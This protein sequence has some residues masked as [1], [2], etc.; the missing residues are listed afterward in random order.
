M[1]AQIATPYASIYETKDGRILLAAQF[2][3]GQVDIYDL[4]HPKYQVTIL[5]VSDFKF[6]PQFHQDEFGRIF[7]AVQTDYLDFYEILSE[8]RTQHMHSLHSW[9]AT[10]WNGH[11]FTFQ[12]QA[13]FTYF[14]SLAQRFA[15]LKL[16]EGRLDAVEFEIPNLARRTSFSW[17]TSADN[18]FL[19]VQ[20]QKSIRIFQL[21]SSVKGAK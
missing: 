13:H 7:L 4:K 19:G 6:W 2:H 16:A 21:I 18:V 12:G 14:D 9:P 3:K 1:T 10:Y 5:N 8:N 17:Y 11:W 20:E 15:S